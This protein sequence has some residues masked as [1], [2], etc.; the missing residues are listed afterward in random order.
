MKKIILLIR[1]YINVFILGKHSILDN[2]FGGSEKLKIKYKNFDY[3]FKQVYDT[4]YIYIL[5]SYDDSNGECVI[6]TIDKEDKSVIITSLGSLDK[7]YNEEINVGSNLLKITLKMIR[8]YKDKL[9]VNKILLTDNTIYYCNNIKLD[10]QIMMTL[11]EGHTWYGKYGFRPYNKEG[12]TYI[13]DNYYNKIYDIN[14]QIMN[15]IKIKDI[16]FN[17]YLLLINEKYPDNFTL[18]IIDIFNLFLENNKD[19]LVKDFLKIINKK[20]I[21]KKTCDYFNV[22]YKILFDDLQLK[23]INS[24]YGLDL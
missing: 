12:N 8:K 17:K 22:Y 9:G 7:Y 14:L 2:Q 15:T 24:Y 4:E 5:Y 20:D 21:F 10:L 18:E 1:N 6:L 19:L 3:I 11:F 13:L 23:K 16:N